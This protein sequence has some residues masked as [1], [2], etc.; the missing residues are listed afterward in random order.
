MPYPPGSA[1]ALIYPGVVSRTRAARCGTRGPQAPAPPHATASA[2]TPARTPLPHTA[3]GPPAPTAADRPRRPAGP[4]GSSP[5]RHRPLEGA[6]DGQDGRHSPPETR[7]ARV[8]SAGFG[9]ETPRWIGRGPMASATPRPAPA[10]KFSIR[11]GRRVHKK[12]SIRHP[13]ECPRRVPPPQ[14]RI[15]KLG[16]G[17]SHTF[18]SWPPAAAS[19]SSFFHHVCCSSSDIPPVPTPSLPAE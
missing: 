6:A 16:S 7:H 3:P 1:A 5:P 9:H 11:R 17:I 18:G 12:K 10:H 13:Y 4:E 19:G 15:G 2:A 14:K 8:E